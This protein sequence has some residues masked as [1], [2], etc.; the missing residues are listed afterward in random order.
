MTELSL[1]RHA[2]T[3]MRQRGYKDEDVD[4]VFRV[5]TRVADDAFLL[6]DK[7]AARAIRKRKQ[8]IQQ[9]E[10]LRGSQVIVEGETLITLYHTTMRPRRRNRKSWRHS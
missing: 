7:D 3:R 1:T 5:G 4:L 9:L 6:T 2:E 10:R 8:E